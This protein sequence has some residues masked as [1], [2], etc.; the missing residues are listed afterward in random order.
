[1]IMLHLEL[2]Q[3]GVWVIEKSRLNI[4]QQPLDSRQ[5]IYIVFD[6][7]RETQ[8]GPMEAISTGSRSRLAI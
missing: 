6:P 8:T 4:G 2:D 1:M 3:W 7:S 5:L